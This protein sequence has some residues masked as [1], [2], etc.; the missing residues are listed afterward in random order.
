M[1][2]EKIIKILEQ[3]IPSEIVAI[4]GGG[5]KPPTKGHFFVAKETLNQF[6]E[7]KE[8]LI[9]VGG[10]VRDNI[11]QEQSLKI[12]EIYKPYLSPKVKILSSTKGPIGEAI[13]LAKKN[14]QVKYYVILGSRKGKQDD[15][16]DIKSRNK[17]LTKYPNIEVKVIETDNPNIS[18]TNARAAAKRFVGDLVPF[19]PDELTDQ[20]YHEI[21][22][23]LRQT[24]NELS[25]NE[26]K[27]WALQAD[28]F[29]ILRD[30]PEKYEKLS[31]SL[32]GLRKEALD[33]FWDLIQQSK[34][35]EETI[36]PPKI[37]IKDVKFKVK[38]NK[39]KNYLY[40]TLWYKGDNIGGCVVY[41]ERHPYINF[42]DIDENYRG[43]GLGKLFYS[44][45]KKELNKRGLNLY[46]Y[47]NLTDDGKRMWDKF[48]DW[49]WVKHDDYKPY[50]EETSV[51]TE[52]ATYK[53]IDFKNHIKNYTKYFTDIHPELKKNLPKIILKNGNTK[54]ASDFF[55]KTAY[56]DPI[57]KEIILYTEGRHPKDIVRSYA[58]ELVHHLQNIQ[59]RLGNI[60]TTNTNEDSNLYNLEIEA[61]LEGNIN[62]RNWTDTLNENILPQEKFAQETGQDYI[63]QSLKNIPLRNKYDI[64]DYK[65]V[66]LP[67]D[68]VKPTQFGKEYINPSSEYEAEQ[69]R[70]YI[71]GKIG[72]EDLRKEDFYP[73]IV[74]KDTME[75]ID[76][77]HRHAV[78][79][80]LG[81]PQIKAILVS[82][83]LNE[84]ISPKEA[85]S[86][87]SAYQTVLNN[88]RGL[89][90][91]TVKGD[92]TSINA[93]DETTKIKLTNWA[94]K[95]KEKD[96][97]N[98]LRV[99]ENP[100]LAYIYYRNGYGKDAKELA[101]IASKY[102]GFLPSTLDGTFYGRD[103][104]ELADD[105]FRIGQLLGYN[106]NEIFDFREKI[107]EKKK[108]TGIDA[109]SLEIL[110]QTL[111]E[112]AYDSIVTKL[113]NLTLQQWKKD[114][115]TGKKSS[116]LDIDIKE[117]DAKGRPLEFNYVSKV[118]FDPKE[119]TYTPDGTSNDGSSENKFAFIATIFKINPKILP[120][121]WSKIS[122][123]L[124]DV[125]RHEIEHLTQ[126]GKNVRI[127][128][129][130]PNDD[131]IRN[132]INN[133]KILPKSD[134][135]K[136]EKEINAI[137]QGLYFKAKKSKTSFTD[138]A[139]S[140]LDQANLTKEE[141]EE[142]FKLWKN[143]SKSLS[144]PLKENL[145]DVYTIYLDMDGVIADF[146]KRFKQL[147][148]KI[149][150]DFE[151]KFGTDKFWEVIDKDGV[152]FW[153]GIPWTEDGKELYNFVK[154]Y[155]HNLLSAPS[156]NNT[157]RL[158]KRLWRKNNTPESKLI[159][160]PA[161]KKQ[162]YAAPSHILIDDREKTINQW[163][164][165]GGI[166]ILHKNTQDTIK[167]LKKIGL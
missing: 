56:Y 6:P 91:M 9:L 137:L 153:V 59:N 44:S 127:S 27:Y 126:G 89:G 94:K 139:N 47:D 31:Q 138:V 32:T 111:K 143:K 15:L 124:K 109:F 167:Q 110:K 135:F 130:L 119:N 96:G 120:Q 161:D 72:A 164:A 113:S 115:Q 10:G 39:E 92:L 85:Y 65:V 4:Y 125:I 123:D 163:I 88:K 102:D 8:L 149:P 146:N 14:P 55:G 26:L 73:I 158:G 156:K 71:E 68:K 140:Y 159:L 134:Y 22:S 53:N 74:D 83:N 154:Q 20:Q 36:S 61:Y 152:K 18:G 145:K 16:E 100:Y 101:K 33:Y 25:D 128:K 104:K 121:S 144:L 43:L 77:N 60:T 98:L 64:K 150:K 118:I 81:I 84:S 160:S 63:Q 132:L 49:G 29:S 28:L 11:T 131:E 108:P 114:F 157:S 165:K 45:I 133:L 34:L 78:H 5:F 51:L 129:Q 12:W 90:F 48:E 105:I 38:H 116:Y 58:H 50:I 148:G 21:H 106:E 80:M 41:L 99:P 93:D 67:L 76:G 40:F 112:G 69:Y 95:V 142:I 54:N 1:L 23:I 122:M 117:T 13:S 97:L 62:F 166:G 7:I 136:L 46:R 19:L 86:L 82:K 79:K 42:I 30:N 87:D 37:N 57:N 3:S 35:N 147:T 2:E 155:K 103:K 162:N 70:K 141:K 151:Q 17:Q 107:Q 75:I 66:T 52:Q 24:L